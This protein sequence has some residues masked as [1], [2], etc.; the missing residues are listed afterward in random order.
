[1]KPAMDLPRLPPRQLAYTSPLPGYKLEP[2]APLPAPTD[3]CGANAQ[4]ARD[5]RGGG[6]FIAADMG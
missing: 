4:A 2:R 6:L 5:D 3:F 1:M